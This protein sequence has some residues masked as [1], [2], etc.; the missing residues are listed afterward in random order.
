MTSFYINGNC[1]TKSY[2]K[3]FI[4]EVAANRGYAE[5]CFASAWSRVEK[6]EEAREF[7]GE[8]SDYQLEIVCDD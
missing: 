1:T 5:E 2:A 4:F 3:Q 8:L 6:S 7:I